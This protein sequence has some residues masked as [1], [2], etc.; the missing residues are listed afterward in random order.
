MQPFGP[1]VRQLQLLASAVRPPFRDSYEAFALQRL[2]V[3]GPV[4]QDGRL[5]KSSDAAINA[6]GHDAKNNG[7]LLE[8]LLKDVPCIADQAKTADER[9]AIESLYAGQG[10]ICHFIA[11]SG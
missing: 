9:A 4:Q 3:S 2:N 11:P 7:A 10:L 8:F 5:F 1:G 6:K